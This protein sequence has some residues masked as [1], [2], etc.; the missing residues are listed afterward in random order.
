MKDARVEQLADI[1]LDYSV[2]IKPGENL[3]IELTGAGVPLAEALIRGAYKR[4]ARPFVQVRELRLQRALIREIDEEHLKK[5][6]EFELVQMRAMQAYIGIRGTENAFEMQDVPGERHRWYTEQYVKPLHLEI[7]VPKTKWCILRFPTAGL[8]QQAGM[9]TEAFEDLFFQVC[10][11]DYARMDQAMEALVRRMAATDRVRVVGPGTDLEF[12]IKGI[13]AI[14]CSGKMNLPDGEVFTAP[15]KTSVNGVLTYNVPAVYQGTSFQNIRFRFADG[16]I[17]EATADGGG[18]QRLN[19]ILDTDEG[20]RY[21]GEFSFGLNPYLKRPMQDALFDEKID[22]S[23]HITPGS[24]YDE[25]DNGNR[26]AIHWDLVL[27][28][29]PELGGGSVYFDGELIRENGRFVPADLQ[30]L[31]PETLIAG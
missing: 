20:A 7:R 21:L 24:A 26:S 10:N 4:G 9:S 15:V 11:L 12:S 5:W 29:R 2:A 6:A 13:P 3:L 16:K 14:K 30:V 18:T 31:N 22:G 1:L 19:E 27:V 17:V 28:Q 25:A 8:A 23:L